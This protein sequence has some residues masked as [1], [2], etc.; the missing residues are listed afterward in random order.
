MLRPVGRNEVEF[1]ARLLV[2]LSSAAN[3]ALGLSLPGPEDPPAAAASGN[4]R[5]G[6]PSLGHPWLAAA[7]DA[8][9][10]RGLRVNLRPLAEKATLLW[11]PVLFVSLRLS[12]WL[13]RVVWE[14]V[15]APY[16]P[17]EW[18]LSQ[19][20]QQHLSEQ[21]AAMTMSEHE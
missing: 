12:L 7:R 8:A 14:V 4:P 16:E 1:L 10:G 21:Q 15:T 9:A 6:K 13:L 19:Q 3:R 11:L 2:R 20:Q 18:E 17:G 5:L